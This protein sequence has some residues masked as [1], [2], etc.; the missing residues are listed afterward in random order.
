MFCYVLHQLKLTRPYRKAVEVTPFGGIEIVGLSWLQL[1]AD[2]AHWPRVAA[3]V[4]IG[5]VVLTLPD[6]ESFGRDAG[7]SLW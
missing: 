6:L 7:G 4:D 2:G 3:R 5:V 1:S